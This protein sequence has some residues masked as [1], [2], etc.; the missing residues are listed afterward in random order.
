MHQ[1]KFVI[2]IGWTVGFFFSITSWPKVLKFNPLSLIT[3]SIH[4]KLK[5]AMV[6]VR[7]HY[8]ES[9]LERDHRVIF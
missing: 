7:V 8:S 5:I 4:G 1:G 2:N 9:I 6:M 3:F